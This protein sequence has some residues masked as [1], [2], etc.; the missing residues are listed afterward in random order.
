MRHDERL[1]ISFEIIDQMRVN[2]AR[3]CDE[4][5]GFANFYRAMFSVGDSSAFRIFNAKS[6]IAAKIKECEG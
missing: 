3:A 6:D 4:A 1:T 5:V 2:T